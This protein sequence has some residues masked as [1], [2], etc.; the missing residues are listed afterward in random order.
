MKT[1]VPKD[2]GNDR[3]WYLVDAADKV[4]GRLAVEITNVLRGRNKPTYTPHVDTGDFVVVVNAEKVKLTGKKNE[5]KLYQSYSG[6]RS[7]LYKETADTVR[8]RHPDRLIRKAVQGMLPDN[9]ISRKMFSRLKV[10][11]GSEHP[12]EAQKPQVVELL[13]EK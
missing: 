1:F 7:G 12:H 8:K 10:Y 4:L 13:Q 11:A 2:P 3:N 5:K 6:Y 9:N